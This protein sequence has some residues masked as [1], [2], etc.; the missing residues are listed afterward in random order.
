MRRQ[1]GPAKRPSWTGQVVGGEPG[2]CGL[3]GAKSR[4][5]SRGRQWLPRKDRGTRNAYRRGLEASP[6][7]YML[8]GSKSMTFWKR[9]NHGNGKR[10]VAARGRG[11]GR[12]FRQRCY[13]AGHVTVAPHHC[14]LSRP[15][16]RTAPGV[17]PAGCGASVNDDAPVWAHAGCEQRRK[18]AGTGHALPKSSTSIKLLQK[19]KL[20]KHQQQ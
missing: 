12:F 8:H 13:P 14:T 10:R 2:G 19:Q 9:Q 4:R 18:V 6:K 1:E 17:S 5:C 20:I 15:T 16:G 11:D 7:A 3:L